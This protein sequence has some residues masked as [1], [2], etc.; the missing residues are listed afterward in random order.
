MLNQTKAFMKQTCTFSAFLSLLLINNLLFAADIIIKDS[1]L[2]ADVDHVWSN[3]NTYFL[4][5]FVF[6]ETG[7]T[8]TIEA[9]TRIKA[10][11]SPSTTDNASALIITRGAKIFA[12]GTANNPIIFTTEFD[13]L[14][15]PTDIDP[16]APEGKGLWG[17]L[18]VLGK[19]MIANSTP[20]EAI[21]GIPA[22]EARA[23]YGGTDDADNSGVLRYISIRHGGA[24]LAPGD[25]INGLTLGGVGSD[26]Q[27]EYVEIIGN[28]D[29]GIEIFGGTVAIKYAVVAF[30]GD[31]AFD[32]DLG[33]RG[34]GQFWF[35]ISGAEDGDHGGEH[36][37]AKP[38]EGEPTSNPTIYNA[39]YI[40]GGSADGIAKNE[41]A[42][43]FRDGAAGTYANSI[44]TDYVNFALQV[45]DR[46]EGVDSRQRMEDGL[47]NLKNNVWWDFGEGS[48]LN[49]GI[50]GI[51]SST[52]DA[53]DKNCQFL[54]NHL[55]ANGNTLENPELNNIG[56]TIGSN[57]DP[58]PSSHAIT[59]NLADYADNYFTTVE[60]KGAFHP[61]APLWTDGWTALDNQMFITSTEETELTID[62]FNM[63]IFPNPVSE[64]AEIQFMLHMP[65]IITLSIFD[66][67]GKEV[68]RLINHTQY[69]TGQQKIKF[70][71]NRLQTGV[72]FYRLNN[73][74]HS[75]SNSFVLQK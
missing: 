32:Y 31:D 69:G 26:S 5:G 50:N 44:I 62:H 11:E 51:L 8:L 12:E 45:E 7:G 70:N 3:F 25:E 68:S 56:R 42:L 47:L 27:I 28:E 17:G 20:E 10:L 4:D 64:T 43:I 39:T 66:I 2:N 54:I 19:G 48:E 15:D 22:G 53:E 40:G 75:I 18:I 57:F 38:D 37:G 35:A 21:D 72:Y 73:G 74:I 46:A 63:Q 49:C 30:C 67:Q 36:D 23:L 29:D 6:L 61:N 52:E 1:D 34:K 13:D 16:T 65:Q 60:Y 41:H 14:S 55:M 71:T 9:G 24:E 33:W 58:R 59:Q